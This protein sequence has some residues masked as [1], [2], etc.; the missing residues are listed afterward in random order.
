MQD[1]AKAGMTMVVVTHEMRFAK[2]V[3]NR[4]IFMEHGRIVEQGTS[5]E[6][7]EH[8]KEKRTREFLRMKEE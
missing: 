1:L 3:S 6:M 4:V 7:F 8:P 2:D 5:E